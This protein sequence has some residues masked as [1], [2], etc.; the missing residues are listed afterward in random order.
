MKPF[1]TLKYEKDDPQ[2]EPNTEVGLS[3]SNALVSGK[4]ELDKIYQFSERCQRRFKMD[5]HGGIDVEVRA[6]HTMPNDYGAWVY[7]CGPF[8]SID[9]AANFH[10]LLYR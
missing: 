4:F 3:D 1:L 2:P 9:E 10:E 7:I 5:A 8:D 6:L